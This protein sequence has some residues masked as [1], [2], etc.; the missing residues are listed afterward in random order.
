M[1]LIESD[2]TCI[3]L[4]ETIPIHPWT[5]LQ[6]WFSLQLHLFAHNCPYMLSGHRS[7]QFVPYVPLG[8]AIKN[9]Q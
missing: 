8:H 5:L 1:I 2:Y 4:F 7:E 9:L 6:S 3:Q